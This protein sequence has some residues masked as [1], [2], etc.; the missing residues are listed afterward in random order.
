MALLQLWQMKLLSL[1]ALSLAAFGQ[2]APIPAPPSTPANEFI[3]VFASYQAYSH[4]AVS[5]GIAYAYQ[6]APNSLSAAQH[7]YMALE[8]NV[9][10]EKLKP[11]VL[12]SVARGGVCQQVLDW[13]VHLFTCGQLSMATAGAGSGVSGGVA[14][15][16]LADWQI[17]K[18]KWG[19]AAEVVGMKSALSDPGIAYEIGIR[20]ARR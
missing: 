18:T 16:I 8:Y 14:G 17:G 19:I 9:W 4:P 12:Q 5:G 6:L 3:A 1:F 7:T 20:R 15:T 10:P 2:S 11:F 13:P